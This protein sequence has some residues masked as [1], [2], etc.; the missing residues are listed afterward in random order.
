MILAEKSSSAISRN[1]EL[2]ETASQAALRLLND[3][4][5]DTLIATA[6]WAGLDTPVVWKSIIIPKI[7]FPPPV[8][9]DGNVESHYI[10]SRNAA[11]RRMRQVIGRGLRSADAECSIIICDPRWSKIESFIPSRF[12]Q[13]WDEKRTYSE[14]AVLQVTLSKAERDGYLRKAALKKYGLV[15]HVC[16]WKPKT[17]NQIQIHHLDPIA[18]GERKTSLD[19]VRPL[20]GNCHLLAHSV[21]PPLTL[22]QMKDIL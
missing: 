20:C 15:C 5:K 11:I 21:R 17:P 14:G 16:D 19:D 8:T 13:A 3:D 18:E 9:L 12:Q 1:Q 7:P 2:D 10:S 22:E 6:A 4:T